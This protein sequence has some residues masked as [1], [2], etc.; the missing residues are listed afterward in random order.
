VTGVPVL[1]THAWIWWVDRD[2][3]LGRSAVDALDR[4]PAETRPGLC[5]IS[6]W[7]VAM[8]VARG[9][10]S[11]DLPLREWLEAAAHPRTIRLLPVTPEIAAEVAALPE[12]FHRDPR[13]D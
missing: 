3:R 11:F 10:L 13:T 9:R 2:R 8:L 12:T 7:E 1:D 4:L 6:L 5:D